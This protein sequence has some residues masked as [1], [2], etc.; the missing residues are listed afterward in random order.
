MSAD[1]RKIPAPVRKSSAR[2]HPQAMDT[3]S[4]A[5]TSLAARSPK[6]ITPSIQP[7][8]TAEHS[9]P[10]FWDAAP[11]RNSPPTSCDLGRP[12]WPP[13]FAQ[14]CNGSGRLLKMVNCCCAVAG[15]PPSPERH[16]AIPSAKGRRS[17]LGT[18]AGQ[19][20]HTPSPSPL[21]R[22]LA[23][24]TRRRRQASDEVSRG[25]PQVRILSGARVSVQLRACFQT[26]PQCLCPGCAR[27]SGK[28][29]PPRITDL[30]RYE[31]S[32]RRLRAT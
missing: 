20:S 10:R 13:R 9:V 17:K 16:V 30:L 6:R 32:A 19:P 1:P 22:P 28:L 23:Q 24:G 18:I 3:A 25:G 2:R 7:H 29:C 31:R 14:I 11:A 27:S 5:I 12:T 4:V 15:R 21:H 26:G 8:I